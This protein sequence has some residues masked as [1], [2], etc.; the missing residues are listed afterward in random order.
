MDEEV[1]AV[2]DLS[3]MEKITKFF[4][5]QMGRETSDAELAL[6]SEVWEAVHETD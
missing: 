4:A 2:S 6:I 3:P 5:Q 1:Q